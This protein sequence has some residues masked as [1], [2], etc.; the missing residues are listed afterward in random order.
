[1]NDVNTQSENLQLTEVNPKHDLN[2]PRENAVEPVVSNMTADVAIDKYRRL[3]AKKE[4]VVAEHKKLIAQYDAALEY[5]EG[6]LLGTMN[7]Q[8]VD[9][10]SVKSDDEK[11]GGTVFKSVTT[12]ASVSKW[13]ETLQYILDTGR[14]ELLEPR[15]SKNAVLSIMEENG[16]PVPGVTL[17]Q[18]INVNVRKA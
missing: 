17:F 14:V 8:G 3:R 1:M 12:H 5:L 11:F 2:L 9:S 13:S 10:I 4:E 18:R 16:E 7:A 15:V 6:V